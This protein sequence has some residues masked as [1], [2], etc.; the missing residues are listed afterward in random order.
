MNGDI[1]KFQLITE[2]DHGEEGR[3]AICKT[4]HDEWHSSVYTTDEE[5]EVMKRLNKVLGEEITEVLWICEDCLLS[6]FNAKF[7]SSRTG[8]RWEVNDFVRK[9]E[10]II[11]G[12]KRS[13]PVKIFTLKTRGT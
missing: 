13:E 3:C 12:V 4:Y 9:A 6:K 7:Y 11:S 5:F 2:G 10:E 8:P 1:M